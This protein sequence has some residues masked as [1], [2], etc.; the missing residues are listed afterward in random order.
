MFPTH[1]REL[2]TSAPVF[3]STIITLESSELSVIARYLPEGEYA[4]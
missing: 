4:T 1:L 3:T 2:A